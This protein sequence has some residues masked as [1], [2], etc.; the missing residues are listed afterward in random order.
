M[1]Q[2]PEII[3]APFTV[4]IAP[5]GTPFPAPN[6]EP[7][8][9]WTPVG[10]SG[11]RSYDRAGVTVSHQRS[12]ETAIPA[13]MTASPFAFLGSQSMRVRVQLLD[14]SLEQYS[15]AL[16]GNP[17][18]TVAISNGA[19][20]RKTIGLGIAARTQTFFALM[21]R[22]QSPYNND[23]PAQFELPRCMEG[24][25]GVDFTFGVSNPVQTALEFIVL[26]DPAATSEQTI[27]GRLLA[28]SDRDIPSQLLSPGAAWNGTA[29]SGFSSTPSD[30]ARTT[31]KP[32]IRPLDPPNQYF[33]DELTYSVMAFARNGGTLDGGIDRVRF[34]FEGQTVDVVPSALRIFTRYDGT[35]Y[36]L[37]CYTVRLKKP[38]GL[39]GIANLYVEAI[40]ADPTMQSRVLGPIAFSPADAR[41]DWDRTIGLTGSGAD[42]TAATL[43]T[44]TT[45]A[46]AAAK[47]AAANN[48]RLTFISSGTTD[49]VHGTPNYTP[50]GYLTFECASGVTVTFGKASY[51][52]DT[53]MLMRTRY[54][55]MW[56]RGAGFTFDMAFVSEIFHEAQTS[57]PFAAGSRSHVFEGVRFTR[58][59]P[60]GALLRK[61]VTGG[62]V[63]WSVRGSPWF[64]DCDV[65]NMQCPGQTSHLFRGCTF[66]QGFHDVA[67]GVACMA[68]CTVAGW[69]S[70][71]YLAPVAAMTVTYTGAGASA[72]LSLSGIS[73]ASTRT[74]TARV[75]GV[76]V[77]TFTVL[78]SEAAF[79][80]GTNYNVA[81]V[82][83]WINSL[84]DWSA[85][86]Q[87]DT[88]RATALTTGAIGYGAFTNVNTKG[89]TLQLFTAFD[90][91]TDFYQKDSA[92]LV[93]N[94]LI[95][96]NTG[97]EIDAQFIMIGG[98][99]SRDWA[100]INNALDV[101]AGSIDN[102]D[103][104]VLQSQ[105]AHPQRHVIFA[106]NSF[107]QQ[108]LALRTGTS[109]IRLYDPDS[110]CLVANN[111][112]RD[113]RWDIGGV[114]ADLAIANNH[115]HAGATGTGSPGEV[116]SGDQTSLFVDFNAGNF[117][118]AGALL[119]NLK[120]PV[121]TLDAAAKS[122]PASAPVGALA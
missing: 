27:F 84:T 50:Q 87:D 35:T 98:N 90:L 26:H 82:V 103:G 9:P 109:S 41:H 12:Y 43:T 1:T 47:T 64:M 8:A 86:L 32:I 18:E 39:A 44:A 116:K 101:K 13:G 102:P 56:F 74:F 85:T 66:R 67:F 57:V 76:S 80:A 93:E 2:H 119:T 69:S 60:A 20:A 25:Q 94:V 106:H 16:G 78:N 99:E 105:F 17:V 77:G 118:P 15:H 111:A 96:G 63:T 14:F 95:Y 113:L 46:I 24:G 117:A 97:T 120:P 79:T 73:D 75:N 22:G 83:S 10:T 68:G 4:W 5:L 36:S 19:L 71:L 28:L 110:Y 70:D 65:H 3:A 91:H 33:T 6:A 59:T 54:D 58:S 121:F 112:L 88:R 92:N 31:A 37:P 11:A 55:G 104:T 62:T 114:D 122:R 81:N 40:P 49:L 30:P 53:A 45:N 38:A 61:A 52:T 107:P 21:L 48:P 42:Y 108:T 51:T 29:G 100:V 34:H 23:L 72:D 115:L 7:A 89:V